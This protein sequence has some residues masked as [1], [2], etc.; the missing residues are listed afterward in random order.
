MIPRLISYVLI[1]LSVLIYP[2]YSFSQVAC[3][4]PIMDVTMYPVP[5]ECR[6]AE[7][8][9]PEW[10]FCEG[11]ESGDLGNWDEVTNGEHVNVMDDAE[12]LESMSQYLFQGH[13]A[14][15][16]FLIEE[17]GEHHQ[18]RNRYI[19]KNFNE[20]LEHFFARGC[21]YI[22]DVIST[23]IDRELFRFRSLQGEG[24]AHSWEVALTSHDLNLALELS[25]PADES[26]EEG[27]DAGNYNLGYLR[28]YSWNCI[29]VE[30][31]ANAPGSRDG[32]VNVWADARSLLE[33]KDINL[34][35]EI[36]TGIG[37]MEVGRTSERDNYTYVDEERFWDNIIVSHELIGTDNMTFSAMSPHGGCVLGAEESG[38]GMTDGSGRA[39][40]FS[41]IMLSALIVLLAGR[42]FIHR[43]SYF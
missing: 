14:Q 33:L 16:D 2:V 31:K 38:C 5:Y 28:R 36:E 39:D 4:V 23:G 9:H 11:F 13:V 19:T 1:F 22:G 35:G 6:L 42:R 3:A 21:L 8:E 12:I 7:T 20:G 29:E 32:M 37:T 41:L 15:F 10:L 25:P 34:R 43:F 26:F 27:D 17:S 24:S 30:I 40:L 18:V